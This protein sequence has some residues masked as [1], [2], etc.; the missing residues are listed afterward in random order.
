M[1]RKIDWNQYY[2]RQDL[3]FT[4]RYIQKG[5]EY[6]ENGLSIRDFPT[7][8]EL[9]EKEVQE[10]SK[11]K[12]MPERYIFSARSQKPYDSYAMAKSAAVRKKLDLSKIKFLEFKRGWIIDKHGERNQSR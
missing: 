3:G 8:E 12:L 11:L 6:D 7:P 10:L 4:K 2:V 5:L 1:R 9:D